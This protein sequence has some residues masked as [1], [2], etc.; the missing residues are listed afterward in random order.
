M[1]K[2]LS[3]AVD[4]GDR[5]DTRLF[6]RP[7][8]C[9][10]SSDLFGCCSSDG[11]WRQ[12]QTAGCGYGNCEWRTTDYCPGYI[13]CVGGTDMSMP[14]EIYRQER[15]AD[16]CTPCGTCICSFGLAPEERFLTALCGIDNPC[17]PEV[18]DVPEPI[19]EPI[20]WQD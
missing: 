1:C 2:D 15:Y 12:G 9:T 19:E 5:R 3:V 6:Q 11:C 10:A 7:V 4:D 13:Q 14:P 8:M 17:P 20:N 18:P 16:I